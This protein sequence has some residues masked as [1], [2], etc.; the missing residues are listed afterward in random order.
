MILAVT[1]FLMGY[2]I[3]APDF[4]RLISIQCPPYVSMRGVEPE[5]SR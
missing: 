5:C 4:V 2:M 1:A 3:F